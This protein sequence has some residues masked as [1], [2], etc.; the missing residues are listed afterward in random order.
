M[1]TGFIASKSPPSVAKYKW[2]GIRLKQGEEKTVPPHFNF[3]THFFFCKQESKIL[4]EQKR[5]QINWFLRVIHK[6]NIS[7][8]F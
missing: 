6:I 2:D 8:P 3:Q 1:P 4:K 7:C 5:K